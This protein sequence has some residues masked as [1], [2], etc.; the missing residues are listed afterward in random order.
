MSLAALSISEE[1]TDKDWKVISNEF[2]A[3]SPE[4]VLRW[5]IEEF[6]PDVAL[7]TGFGAEGCVLV[8]MLS[9]IRP[10]S[11]GTRIFYL[12]TDL[13]FPE[14]YALRDQLE[15]RYGVHFERRATS[16][17][18]SDQAAQYGERLWE[19]EPDLCCRLRK[20][21]PLREM[22]QGMRAWVTAIRRDQSA[23]RAGTDLVERDEKFGLVKI[24]PLAA[25]SAR[26]VWNYIAKHDVPYNT[27]HEQ[28]YPSIGCVPCTTPVQIGE[29]PRAGRW[30]GTGK[31]EC[32]IH[33]GGKW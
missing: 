8:S 29:M 18:V 5:A 2:E 10:I 20:V 7:A 31:S 21:E 27:L 15:A 23:A 13:L 16:L 32:G 4:A 19:R 24:N 14:T 6:A 3:A 22:L 25:W 12:D 30:R 1:T 26:D 33:E 17:S 28:G 9:A 11:Q